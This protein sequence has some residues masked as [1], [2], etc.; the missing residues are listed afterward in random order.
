MLKGKPLSDS[1]QYL[2][3]FGE[4]ADLQFFGEKPWTASE[5]RNLLL[6]SLQ[7]IITVISNRLTNKQPG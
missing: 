3:K 6:K 7:Y 1:V 2:A 5:L 4:V